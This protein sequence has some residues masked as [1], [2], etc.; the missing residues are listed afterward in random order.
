MPQQI[1]RADDSLQGKPQVREVWCSPASAKESACLGD[2]PCS[3]LTHFPFPREPLSPPN[4][5]SSHLSAL[6]PSVLS[7]EGRG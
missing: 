2:S 1:T 4:P 3:A 6:L 5:F 7:K